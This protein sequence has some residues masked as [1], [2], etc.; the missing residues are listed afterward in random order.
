[1]AGGSL[2]DMISDSVSFTAG[3]SVGFNVIRQPLSRNLMLPKQTRTIVSNRQSPDAFESINSRVSTPY[4]KPDEVIS[5]Q[6]SE[7]IG[8][9][10]KILEEASDSIGESGV[11]EPLSLRETFDSLAGKK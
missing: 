5:N 9:N 8:V 7:N 2:S 1:M 11:F 4:E 10:M 3:S 6:A